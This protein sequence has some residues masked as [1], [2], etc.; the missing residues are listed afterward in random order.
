MPLIQ[1]QTN[2]LT[3]YQM[4]SWMVK[5][6]GWKWINSN[7]HVQLPNA[8]LVYVPNWSHIDGALK[9]MIIEEMN[10]S[11]TQEQ[12]REILSMDG[13]QTQIEAFQKG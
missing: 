12:V 4:M 8:G 7:H 3:D 9:D 6:G 1:N 5:F 13:T 10:K 2:N 11:A